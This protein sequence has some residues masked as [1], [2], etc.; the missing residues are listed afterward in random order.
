MGTKETARCIQVSILHSACRKSP[1]AYRMPSLADL[2]VD[3]ELI[4]GEEPRLD[5]AKLLI[6]EDTQVMRP[7]SS[8]RCLTEAA[9]GSVR[10]G[11]A[12][13]GEA[14]GEAR[15]LCGS[16]ALRKGVADGQL[17]PAGEPRKDHQAAGMA[18]GLTTGGSGRVLV[19]E[20][21]IR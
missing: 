1:Q 12:A 8:R 9:V 14:E 3:V 16:A 5:L 19:R 2:I 21:Y 10:E 17:Q 6:A 11:A 20:S 15:R 13:A 7:S 4:H 18:H